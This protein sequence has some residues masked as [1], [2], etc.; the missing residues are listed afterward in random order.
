[1][2]QR[3][4]EKLE[5]PMSAMIDVVFL[6]L[7][8]FI[9]TQKDEL[10]EAHMAINLPSPSSAPSETKPQLLEVQVRAGGNYTLNGKALGLDS[11]ESTL[12]S[13]AQFDKDQTVIVKVH[14]AAIQ[15]ELIELLDRCRKVGLTKLN[16]LTLKGGA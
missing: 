10:I 13:I 14:P 5:T 1:M 7:I 2:R 9:V 8:F 6:L 12:H 15:K 11:L 16:V 4:E 3:E